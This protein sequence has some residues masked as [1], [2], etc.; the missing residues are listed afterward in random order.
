MLILYKMGHIT[1]DGEQFYVET[2]I[3]K[4]LIDGNKRYR[5]K[6]KNKEKHKLK[7]KEY[8][9]K[10]NDIIQKEL[11]EYYEKTG[12]KIS[13]NTRRRGRTPSQAK[14]FE[15]GDFLCEC[16][17]SFKYLVNKERHNKSQKH[18]KYVENLLKFNKEP[19]TLFLDEFNT[20]GDEVFK[21]NF[22]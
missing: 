3:Y 8:H 18:I 19:H 21:L 7:M 22:N 13:Q 1:I 14:Y 11:D 15:P 9:K 4:S 2:K 12:H 10:E 5:N 16:G 20:E 17:A 6:T